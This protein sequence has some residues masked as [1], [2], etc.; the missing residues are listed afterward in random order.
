MKMGQKKKKKKIPE[1]PKQFFGSGGGGKK[2]V[3]RGTANKQFFILG[4]VQFCLK[5]NCW[6]V[7][8]YFVLF[9]EISH[10]F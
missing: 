1:V 3:G 9:S 6:K 10:T 5:W 8:K 4:P 7:Q 2:W